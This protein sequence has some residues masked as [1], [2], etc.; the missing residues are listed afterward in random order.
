MTEGF[1]L[2]AYPAGYGTSGVMSFLVNHIGLVYEKDLGPET[3]K[4]VASM[5]SFAPDGSWAL[6]PAQ[7]L[8]LPSD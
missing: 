1:G 4:K 8:V 6:V 7:A 5:E 3:E 2:L